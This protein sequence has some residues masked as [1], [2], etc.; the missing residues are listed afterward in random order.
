MDLLVGV[1]CVGVGVG[2]GVGIRIRMA[3]RAE[4]LVGGV[5]VE[6]DVWWSSCSVKI[7]AQLKI[8]LKVDGLIAKNCF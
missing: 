4:D 5:I 3:M 8:W 7:D 1:S 6:A 2:T